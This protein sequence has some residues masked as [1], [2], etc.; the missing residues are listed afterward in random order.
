MTTGRSRTVSWNDPKTRVP[1]AEN[2]TGRQYLEMWRDGT[3]PN[4]PFAEL[5]GL[6]LAEVHEGRV[7]F[8]ITPEEFLYNGIGFMHGGVTATLI[9]SAIGCSILTLM[10]P[11]KAAVTLDLHVRYY[12]PIQAESGLLRCEGAILN[13]GRTTAA[14][15]A[16]LV[17]ANGRL[18]AS[19]TSACAIVARGPRS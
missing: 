5:I 16:R 11:G 10:P 12:K 4:P 3:A 19:G 17:D 8:T 9:D 18:Y 1:D 15:E 7:V 13:I 14:A 2:L 6:T